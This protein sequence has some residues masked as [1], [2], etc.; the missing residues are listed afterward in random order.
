MEITKTLNLSK[1]VV[2]KVGS[3]LLTNMNSGIRRSVLN[4]IVSDISWLIKKNKEVIIVSSGAIAIGK[5]M[6]SFKKELSLNESQAVAAR[7]QIELMNAWQKSFKK[8]NKQAL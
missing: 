4:N 8:H 7:G 5:G 2:V 6:L 3:S 1:R